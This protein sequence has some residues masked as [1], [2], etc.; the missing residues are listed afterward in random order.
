MKHFFTTVVLLTIGI[1]VIGQIP[2]DLKTETVL[3][4][5]IAGMHKAKQKPLAKEIGKYPFSM[6]FV[7]VED[8]EKEKAAGAKYVLSVDTQFEWRNSMGMKTKINATQGYYY[9]YN[10]M[11]IATEE[12]FTSGIKGSSGFAGAMKQLVKK[13]KKEYK[14][15]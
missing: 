15:K 1:S 6:K 3:V 8:F 2:T 13:V 9:Y 5:M 4:G 12:I 7:N 10:F 11:D 14:V